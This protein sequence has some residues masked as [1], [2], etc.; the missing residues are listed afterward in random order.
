M[1]PETVAVV[2][3]G[4]SRWTSVDLTAVPADIVVGTRSAAESYTPAAVASTARSAAKVTLASS[5]TVTPADSV[6]PA[7]TL[8]GG[9]TVGPAETGDSRQVLPRCQGDDAQAVGRA[10]GAKGKGKGPPVGVERHDVAAGDGLDASIRVGA[11]GRVCNVRTSEDRIG[12]LHRLIVTDQAD[13]RARKLDGRRRREE[14]RLAG[15]VEVHEV[16]DDT[17]LRR[18]LGCRGQRVRKP[19]GGC[20]RRAATRP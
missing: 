2:M 3:P 14:R 15:R 17:H 6:A 1:L 7:R 9:G 10:G 20:E 11:G 5:N 16:H 4:R 13:D 8:P 18:R 19:P 12:G